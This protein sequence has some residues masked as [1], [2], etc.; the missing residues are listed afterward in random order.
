[1]ETVTYK[2]PN[3]DGGLIYDP[4]TKSFT[5][6]YCLSSFTKEQ[7]E[8]GDTATQEAER[9]TPAQGAQAVRYS[10]PSCGAEVF[11]DETT[12]ATYCFYCHNPVVLSGK[13]EGSLQPDKVIPFSV[14]KEDTITI[15]SNWL[16]KKWFV[17]K[18]YKNISTLE[19]ITG[20][21]FPF[22]KVDCA[23]DGSLDAA[24]TQ[25][26]SWRS[27]DYEYTRTKFY[28]IK[29]KG[30]IDFQGIVKSALKKADRKIVEGAQP[31]EID[32]AEDF[33][34]AYLSGFQAEIRDISTEE[35]LPELN[36]E[37]QSYADSLLRDTVGGYTT[38]TS[39]EVKTKLK[40]PRWCYALCPVWVLTRK[41]KKGETYF[42]AVN[43]QNGKVCG[44]LPVALSRMLALFAAV[45]VPLF[46]LLM[47]GGLLL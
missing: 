4:G 7:L 21:Y 27:G 47:L 24:A 36:R 20:I 12:A 28:A 30:M 37:L 34:M 22:W 35:L 15:F 40:D 14:K 29:R 18:D 10:C 26:N 31:F 13:L 19:Q 42:Y 8:Q 5:C 41:D 38:V 46:L 32:R 23:V 43:G 11:T 33:S 6:E 25:I 16:R 1:M 2:C 17:P 9:G 39:C 45:A 3:C 44:R